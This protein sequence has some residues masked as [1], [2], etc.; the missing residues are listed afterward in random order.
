MHSRRAGSYYNSIDGKFTDVLFDQILPRIR[1]E[2][3]I[4]AGHTDL[5]K[6]GGKTPKFTAIDSAR[7]VSTTVTNI[8]TDFFSHKK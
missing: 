6:G 1:T 3:A 7:N 4:V 2:V 5:R 8:N